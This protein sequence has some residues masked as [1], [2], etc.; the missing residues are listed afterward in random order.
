VSGILGELNSA[1]AIVPRLE[2]RR[3]CGL[4]SGGVR[5]VDA[6]PRLERRRFGGLDSGG[7]W[8]G[9]LPLLERRG[10]ILNAQTEETEETG[11]F[12]I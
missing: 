11:Y 5:A 4:Y 8:G 2:R 1:A 6:I 7:V 9:M 3:S 10:A 12:M